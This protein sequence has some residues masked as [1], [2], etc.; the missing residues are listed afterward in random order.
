MYIFDNLFNCNLSLVDCFISTLTEFI[1]LKL[2]SIFLNWELT[3][4]NWLHIQI[5]STHNLILVS[6]GSIDYG[7]NT[8]W[9]TTINNFLLIVWYSIRS[10]NLYY[11]ILIK[12]VKRFA[13]SYACVC[14]SQYI[15]SNNF[16]IWRQLTSNEVLDLFLRF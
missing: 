7:S 3:N 10:W 15:F 6:F 2:M 16:L 12:L 1:Y 5:H 9:Y 4:H 8:F 14:G 11:N 13:I